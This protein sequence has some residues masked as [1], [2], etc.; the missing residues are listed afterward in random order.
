M[1]YSQLQ[2]LDWYLRIT[3]CCLPLWNLRGPRYLLRL[4]W[5]VM[6]LICSV[7][8]PLPLPHRRRL[9]LILLMLLLPR[10]LIYVKLV[11]R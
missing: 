9:S 10:L 1:Y 4:V 8:W 11:R 3:A 6:T 7:L 5:R 2:H